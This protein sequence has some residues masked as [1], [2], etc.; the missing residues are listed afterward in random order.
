[1][2]LESSH[3]LSS[4]QEETRKA[5]GD[6]LFSGCKWMKGLIPKTWTKLMSTSTTLIIL[7][8]LHSY[9]VS[10]LD[11]SKVI[12]LKQFNFFKIFYNMITIFFS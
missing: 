4:K 10:L 12:Y 5:V 2:A 8:F 11:D 9:C 7:H 3:T 6:V 1:V